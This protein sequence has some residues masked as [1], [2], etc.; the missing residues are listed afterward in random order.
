MAENQVEL[1]VVLTGAEEA[2]RGLK[3]IGETAGKMAERFSDE[4]S[5]L[6]EG[7]SSITGNV[8]EL[9]GSVKEFGAVASSVNKG[10]KMSFLALVPAVGAVVGA[11]Y[12]VYETY[13]LISG[14]AEE[15][16]KR[17]E[18][19]AA[20][21]SDLESK[22]ESLAEKGVVPAKKALDDFIR[23]NLKAQFQKEMLQ[24]AVEKLKNEFQALGEAEEA[25]ERRRK[26]DE[27]LFE[28][29]RSG[30]TGTKL[31]KLQQQ[32]LAEATAD[33]DKKLEGVLKLHQKYLPLLDQTA[34]KEK[35]LEDQ[36]AEATLARVR[37]N[38]ALL[39]TLELRQAEIELTGTE[40]KVKQIE[41]NTAKEAGLVKAKANEED[42]KALAR[43]EKALKQAISSFDQLKQLDKLRAVQQQNARAEADKTN[44][45]ITKGIDTRRIKELALERQRQADLKVLRQLELEEMRL[46][47]ASAIQILNERFA[48][49]I[50]A[51]EGNEEKI[52]IA[53]KRY[54][55]EATRI[56]N[57]E[58]AKR[59]QRRAE[60][61]KRQAEQAK[62]A[63]QI[64]FESLEFDIRMRQQQGFTS[65][66]PG[67][68]D[69]SAI[70]FEQERELDLL[71]LR[72]DRERALAEETQ[73]SI[74][75][76]NRREAIER[77]NINEKSTKAQIEQ[78]AE[79]TST[80]SAGLAESAYNSLL[81]GE[82]FSKGIGDILISLG[83]QAGVQALMETAKGI[84]A[85]IL[86]PTL[87]G[88]YF[89]SAGVFATASAIAGVAGK[90]LG[91]GGGGA[92]GGS[93]SA[94][95]TGSPTTAPAPQREQA[96]QST[97]VF[98]INFGNAT[99]Y[100]TKRSAEQALADRITTLQNTRRRGAP[101]RVF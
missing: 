72:Y 21:A 61:L 31:Y 93:A 62:Q 36:S 91:G 42:A 24:G 79:F 90:A 14:S 33:Y 74:T 78:L 25:I 43:Q 92:S 99:I 68:A 100:D 48:D 32:D 19:M 34:K 7:L 40:L 44:K 64:A 76:I 75:E 80:F 53:N 95:P 9:V 28:I 56:E 38:I 96:E 5:K 69:F 98:N 55:I 54:Q 37:E 58:I 39:N 94:T 70:Q 30:I 18:A 88:N 97:M 10:S 101:R 63:Q 8:E 86:E 51:S 12:A 57:D 27:S 16:E 47:G 4:N 35:A 52:L 71:T 11:L 49:E 45:A 59:E 81:F 89:A 73:T 26:G 29:L 82:S 66:M 77:Q 87:A 46:N 3:G 22:L 65:I 67:V 41:I 17:T 20:A 85:S 15:A 60:E 23:S 84:S 13:M 2:S 1:E 83:K 50:K 6:G